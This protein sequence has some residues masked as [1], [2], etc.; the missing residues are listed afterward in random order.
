M[1]DL[2]KIKLNNTTYNLKDKIARFI[3]IPLTLT[4]DSEEDSYDLTYTG[5]NIAEIS[6]PN[7]RLVVTCPD[8]T[9]KVFYRMVNNYNAFSSLDAN[10]SLGLSTITYSD[11]EFNF[12][13]IDVMSLIDYTTFSQSF[14]RYGVCSTAADTVA[15]TVQIQ[16]IDFLYEGLF[17]FVKFDNTNSASNPT[18]QVNSLVAKSIKRYGTTAPSTSAASSW[19]A[20][21]VQLLVYDGTY[22]QMTDWDNTTYSGMSD[23]EVAAGTS[24]SNRLITPARLKSAIQTWAPITSVNGDTGVIIVDK[25]KT[26]AASDNTEYNLLGT[27]TTDAGTA[28]T[29]LYKQGLISF[30]KGTNEGRLT[31]GS[32]SLPGEVRLYSSVTNASGYTDLKSGT[33]STNTRTITFPDATGTVALTSDIPNV[34]SWALASSKPTYT[35][36]EIGATTS[37]D[38]ADMISQAVSGGSGFSI[39]IVQSLPSTGAANTFYFVPNSGSGDNIYDE[40]LYVNNGWEKI[41]VNGID[42]TGYV[43]TSRTINSKALTSNIS[44]TASD[45]GALPSNTTYVSSF[46]GSTGAITYTAPVTSVNGQTGAVTIAVYDDTSLANRVSA[47]E[48]TTWYRYYTGSSTPSNSMGNNGD[49]YFQQA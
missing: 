23:A 35:A 9:I 41:G 12:T 11:N 19:N 28:A 3:D 15:K 36:S 39:S 21:S 34:P 8:T 47:L 6:L 32:T 43:P 16:G 33:T 30:S 26:T 13:Y 25:V 24:T 18:L 14:M 37:Q 7:A 27:V 20:G 45:V 46:N 48:N 29:N 1:A 10:D 31:I 2:S 4:Y 44:L 42:L 38:V 49:L 22:W 40:Y 17:I 5:S